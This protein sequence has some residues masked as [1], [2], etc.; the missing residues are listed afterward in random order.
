MSHKDETPFLSRWARRK[1]EVQQARKD[2]DSES[3]PPHEAVPHDGA[4]CAEDEPP[5][6]PASLPR[7]DDLTS[8]S[9]VT[10]FLRKGVPEE[11]KRL[12]LRRVWSLD[13]QIRDFVEVAENQYDWNVSGGVPGF[14]ELAEGTD[15]EALLA[16]A[17]G[18][19]RKVLPGESDVALAPSGQASSPAIT[20]S[21]VAPPQPVDN[22]A[23]ARPSCVQGAASAK[24]HGTDAIGHSPADDQHEPR[25]TAFRRRH[26]G[27]LPG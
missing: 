16:Q 27:A 4:E 18:Q 3:L 13:P 9:D 5:F 8:E 15:I 17:T 21:S 12:A 2:S 7:I 6:D 1:Q 24:P 19:L 20:A 11:L 26:G 10:A 23:G 14:G 25:A 22:G